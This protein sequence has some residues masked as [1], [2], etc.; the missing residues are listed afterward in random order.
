VLRFKAWRGLTEAYRQAVEGHTPW[1]QDT[2]DPPPIVTQDVFADPELTAYADTFHHENIRALGFFPLTHQGRL[3]GKFMA[4]FRDVR[5][6]TD[7]ELLLGQTIA[8][9]IGVAVARARNEQALRARDEH[10]HFTLANTNTCTWERNLLTGEIFWS[11]ETYAL[12]GF[13]TAAVPS[14]EAWKNRLHPD[15]VER[16]EQVFA[17]ILGSRQERFDDEFR[18]IH[19]QKGVRWRLS[20]GRMVY[21]EDGTPLR[22]VGINTDITER[23]EAEEALHRSQVELEERVQERTRQLMQ[24]NAVL[25]H[26]V[27]ERARLETKFRG[28]LEAAPDAMVITDD[29]GHIEIVNNQTEAMFG[30]DRGELIGQTVEVLMPESLAGTHRHHRIDYLQHAQ[31]RSMGAGRDLIARRKDGSLFP[32][33]I[34]LSPLNIGAR[35]LMS[36][37]IR[38]ISERKRLETELSEARNRLTEVQERDR[39]YLARELHDGIVQQLMGISYKLADAERKGARRESADIITGM[40]REARE[41]VLQGTRQLR[42]LIRNLRPTGLE[43]LGLSTVLTQHVAE[44]RLQVEPHLVLQISEDGTMLPHGVALCLFRVAQEALRNAL[45]HAKADTVNVALTVKVDE[46]TLSVQDDGQGFALPE[47]LSV[48]ALYN[49]FG[50]LG[51]AEYVEAPT[52]G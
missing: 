43:Q 34:S 12:F 47:R 44:L 50:L 45:R 31:P 1:T 19:P 32:I 4:Y 42:Q 15:D 30:Y 27:D 29:S 5:A 26:E 23:K 7:E 3:L 11:D 6:L 36:S 49:H 10:Y 33:E 48:L 14:H 9:H 8:N 20:R 52:P 28:L 41:D 25:K 46:A 17:A 22:M 18:I 24:A 16:E 40:V 13:E 39:L 35:M 2:V 21:R 38:D 51:L 37:A